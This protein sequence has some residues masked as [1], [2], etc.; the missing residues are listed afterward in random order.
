MPEW[1]NTTVLDVREAVS[2]LK[3]EDGETIALN[4][5]ATL[6]RALLSAKFVGELRLLLHPIVLGSGDRLFDTA[7]DRVDLKL[8]GCMA[9][10]RSP[11]NRLSAD[12][13]SPACPNLRRAAWGS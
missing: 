8:T 10:R 4:G 6:L 1:Q 7:E 2:R 13:L 9:W 12:A 5:N 11:T 3:H